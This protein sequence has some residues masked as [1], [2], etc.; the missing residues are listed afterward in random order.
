MGVVVAQADQP[1]ENST[2]QAPEES[3]IQAVTIPQAAQALGISVVT[4]RRRLKRGELRGQKV[5]TVAG[6]EWRIL[7]PSALVDASAGAASS[8]P[9]QGPTHPGDEGADQRLI[10]AL[11]AQLAEYRT[12]LDARRREVQE[13]HVLLA[14]WQPAL[15]P[16]LTIDQ[17]D[18]TPLRRR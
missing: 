4:V 14:R 9:E 1:P 15:P 11:Q 3:P 8:P 5:P 7:V 12:E 18:Q 13:L 2:A 6:F 16:P 17:A 10:A